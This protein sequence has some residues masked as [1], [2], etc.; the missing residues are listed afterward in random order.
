M[1]LTSYPN[2]FA[3]GVAIHRIPVI[4]TQSPDAKVFWVD[5]V[6]GS[7]GNKGNEKYP[8]ATIAKAVSACRN[9]TG[10][11][12]LVAPNHTETII[13]ETSINKSKISI[14][15][16]GN[17]YKSRPTITFATAIS[18]RWKI[19]ANAIRISNIDFAASITSLEECILIDKRCDIDNCTF[20][21]VG[22]SANSFIDISSAVANTA[23]NTHITNCEFISILGEATYG[24]YLGNNTDGVIID[25]C[26]FYDGFATAC[27]YNANLAVSLNLQI[28][29]C[30]FINKTA[31]KYAIQIEQSTTDGV[32]SRNYMF[33]DTFA[34]TIK[35]AAVKCFECYSTA[36]NDKN[37]RL[38]PVVET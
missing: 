28:T 33:T 32:A 13:A 15:G 38:N 5:S 11:M 12:V 19:N 1:P 27:F 17:G 36:T 16:Y 6:T 2:G 8:F 9:N 34:T 24:V 7:D 25:H 35:P 14:V 3:N 4:A 22:G 29:D 18:A 23:D 31:G 21:F 26:K 30:S 20:Y 10:D 37:A